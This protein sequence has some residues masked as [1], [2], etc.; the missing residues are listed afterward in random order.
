MKHALLL[1]VILPLSLSTQRVDP[2]IPQFAPYPGVKSVEATY[3]FLIKSGNDTSITESF[4]YDVDGM[5]T[6]YGYHQHMMKNPHYQT[7]STYRYQS[8]DVWT[9]KTY[10]NNVLTDSIVVKGRW[11]N[12]YNFY[13]GKFHEMHEFRGDS[14]SEKVLNGLDT[15]VRPNRNVNPTMDPFWDYNHAGAF[16]KKLFVRSTDTDTTRYL[17]ANGKCLVMLV[18]FYDNNFKPVKT[19]YY[20]FNVKRFDLFYLPYSEKMDMTFFLNKSK[21]GH[22]SYEITRKYNEKGWLIEESLT[23]ARPNKGSNGTPMLKL[24]KYEVY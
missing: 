2:R 4:Q 10:K 8:Q 19:H 11:A 24:Y 16:A 21:K 22:W 14:A 18:N 9:Q 3:I 5:L 12:T 6:D 13:Q 7:C 23:D 1:F 17:D 20:N 15:V